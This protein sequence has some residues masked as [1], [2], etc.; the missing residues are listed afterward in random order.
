MKETD[1]LNPKSFIKSNKFHRQLQQKQAQ[2]KKRE[3]NSEKKIL[4][5]NR[6]EVTESR[7]LGKGSFGEIYIAQDQEDNYKYC[8]SKIENRTKN[9]F[10]KIEKNV[11]ELATEVEGFPKLIMFNSQ[12]KAIS[13]LWSY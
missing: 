13:W 3:D 6:F 8:A 12:G 7:L 2:T 9:F 11:L 1:L 10:W 5:G 4:F